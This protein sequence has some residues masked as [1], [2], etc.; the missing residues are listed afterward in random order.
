M[1]HP[2]PIP[3]KGFRSPA[4]FHISRVL[5]YPIQSSLKPAITGFGKCPI[6]GILNITWKRICWRLYPQYL[7][8]VQLGHLPTPY[9]IK[10]VVGGFNCFFLYL[11]SQMGLWST[12]T[13]IYFGSVE[14]ATLNSWFLVISM[15]FLVESPFNMIIWVCLNVPANPIPYHHVPC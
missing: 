7:G 11:S 10:L 6:L 1:S 15:F 14:T 9:K 4:D 3:A 13:S 2:I 5:K 8:D 12:L